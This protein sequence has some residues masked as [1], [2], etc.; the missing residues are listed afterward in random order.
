MSEGGFNM[1]E[2][3][4]SI[5]TVTLDLIN[6]DFESESCISITTGTV[7][8]PNVDENLVWKH[9]HFKNLSDVQN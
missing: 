4:I 5:F 8:N 3:F 9:L 1:T 7:Q 6:E 2:A